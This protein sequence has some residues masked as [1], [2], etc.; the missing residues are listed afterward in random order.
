MHKTRLAKC[1]S[2]CDIQRCSIS[3]GSR[4]RSDEGSP[5]MKQHQAP[6]HLTDSSAN[7]PR[8]VEAPRCKT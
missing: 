3:I 6:C 1:S 7:P 4:H 5:C 2:M 8:E